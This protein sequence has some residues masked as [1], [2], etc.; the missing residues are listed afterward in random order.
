[1][2]KKITKAT[3]T[4]NGIKIPYESLLG[5]RI[6]EPILDE[7]VRDQVDAAVANFTGKI[8]WEKW[9]MSKL[10]S[11]CSLILM[12]GSAGCGKTTCARYLA[13]RIGSGF[14]SLSMGDVGSGDPGQTDRNINSIFDYGQKEGGTTIFIDECD[15]ILLSRDR[16]GPDAMW[17]LTV[18]NCILTRMESYTGCIILATNRVKT[19]DEALL[20]RLTDWIKIPRPSF[21]ARIQLW[22]EK[23]PLE[24]P[25]QL[26]ELKTEQL[27]Q[28]PLSGRDIENCIIAEAKL[29]I[30]QTRNP[31]FE[32]LLQYCKSYAKSRKTS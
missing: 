2:A 4:I 28:I 27:A 24:F 7:D 31:K 22:N 8:R 12:E 3:S 17:M 6:Q 1:M 21:E 15:A 30:R 29:A 13:K 25:L 20:S 16:L 10:R 32:S 18:I 9:G 23:I 11:Q 26:N 19:L 14:I 5:K